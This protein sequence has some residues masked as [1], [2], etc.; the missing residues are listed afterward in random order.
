MQAAA[1][2][3]AAL[4][5]ADMAVGELLSW[6]QVLKERP[7]TAEPAAGPA[8]AH[9]LHGS[10]G[11]LRRCCTAAAVLLAVVALARPQGA[12]GAPVCGTQCR[13]LATVHH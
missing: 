5:S 1:E 13:R 12:A 11:P 8:L 7:G 6:F 10:G 3:A 4:A 9:M 2:P